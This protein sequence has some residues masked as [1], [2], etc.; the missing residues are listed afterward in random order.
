MYSSN[1]VASVQDLVQLLEI[2]AKFIAKIRAKLQQIFLTKMGFLSLKNRK[3]YVQT[4]VIS[5]SNK[6]KKLIKSKSYILY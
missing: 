4:W 1:V 3:K 5:K 6:V 2:V